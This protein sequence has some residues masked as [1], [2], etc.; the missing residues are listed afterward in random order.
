MKNS[1]HFFE[2]TLHFYDLQHFSAM[3]IFIIKQGFLWEGR[4]KAVILL[5]C[6]FPHATFAKCHAKTVVSTYQQ[7]AA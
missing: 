2:T 7:V 6:H 3:G 5:I 1:N 4:G